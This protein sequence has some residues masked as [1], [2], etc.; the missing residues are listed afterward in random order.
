MRGVRF[1]DQVSKA[2]VPDGRDDRSKEGEAA[3]LAVHR[4]LPSREGDVPAAIPALPH[5]E[6]HEP[7]SVKLAGREV[8]FG[9]RQWA[10][11]SE[12]DPFATRKVIHLEA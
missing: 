10:R 1:E 3:S 9:V 5:D 11:R 8:Q 4:V 7:Q 12:S 2:I 6:T